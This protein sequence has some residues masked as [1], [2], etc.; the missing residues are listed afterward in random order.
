MRRL[1]ATMALMLLLWMPTI[2]CAIDASELLPDPQQEARARRLGQEL[3]C[4]VCQNESIDAS[5]ADL[6]RDLRRIV[7]ERIVAGDS[8]QQIRD[9]LVARYGDFVLLKPPF[10]AAT[11]LLWLGPFCLLALGGVL[12]FVVI[13]HRR[14]GEAATPLSESE[15]AELAQ[16]LDQP[17][18]MP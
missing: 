2:A 3:R 9:F 11:L 13:R 8:D 6:A 16:L 5:D 4:L 12:A 17:Q 7:R 10:E 18:K 1:L 14:G 15:Q